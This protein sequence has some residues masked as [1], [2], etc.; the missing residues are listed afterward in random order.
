M[1]KDVT[2]SARVPVDLARDLDLLAREYDRSRSQLMVRAVESYLQYE[3]MFV[4][5][6]KQGLAD[7][8]AGRFVSHEEMLKRFKIKRKKKT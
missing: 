6:V 2:I 8:E 3:Q 4:A 7:L 1:E 5:K